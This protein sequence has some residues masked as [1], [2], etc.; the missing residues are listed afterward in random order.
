MEVWAHKIPTIFTQP[1]PPTPPDT[2]VTRSI[3]WLKLT[4]PP[5][6]PTT[7][8]PNTPL[9]TNIDRCLPFKYLPR[10]CYYTYGSFKPPK[11]T[12]QGHWKREKTGYDIYNPIKS[13][14]IAVRVPGLQNNLRAKM[15]AIHHTLRILTTTYRDE[16]TH[17]FTDCL[18]VMYLLNTQIKHPTLHNS[19]PYK[20]ILKSN[21]AMLHSCTQ[22]TTIHKVKA[23]A[24]IHGHEQANTLAKIGCEL[25]HRDTVMPYDHAHPTPYYL[26]KDWWHS[27]KHQTKAL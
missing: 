11:E 6:P 17:I 7:L 15:M 24:S 4:Y 10:F 14:R 18:S 21:V 20:N 25:D 9:I 3:K 5:H 13:L 16:P 27:K 1:A 22:I 12:S 23:H 19:H 26:Q 2:P 8:T